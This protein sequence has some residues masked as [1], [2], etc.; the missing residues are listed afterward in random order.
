MLAAAKGLPGTG[1]GLPAERHGLGDSD[2]R[3]LF[4]SHLELQVWGEVRAGPAPP[5]ACLLW[6]SLC[7]ALRCPQDTSP[8]ALEPAQ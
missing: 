5:E 7:P 1:P 6:A 2:N 3:S 4:S 8:A